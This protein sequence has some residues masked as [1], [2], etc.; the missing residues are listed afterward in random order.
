[1]FL[2][3]VKS[4]VILGGAISASAGFNAADTPSAYFY[5]TANTAQTTTI[6]TINTPVQL[7]ATT[8]AGRLDMMTMPSGGKFKSTSSRS[9]YASITGDIAIYGSASAYLQT[10]IRK[11]GSVI[12]ATD[13]GRVLTNVEGTTNGVDT[14]PII[15]DTL[16][17]LDDE[18][19][20][21]VE[22][23]LNTSNAVIK[24]VNLRVDFKGWA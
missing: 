17:E 2:E 10:A 12:Y 15:S 18:I 23:T 6:T 24:A 9:F 7:S 16:I 21:W 13:L 11:N 8:T 5:K 4:T 1:M 3:L 14:M 20:I 19:T 22:N